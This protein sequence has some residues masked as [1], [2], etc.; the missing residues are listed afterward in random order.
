MNRGSMERRIGR[1]ARPDSGRNPAREQG[2]SLVEALCA[3]VILGFGLVGITEAITLS[4]RSS[5]N[6][7]YH[8]TAVLLAT[9][10]VETLRAEKYFPTG[11][12]DGDFVD[13]FSLYSWSQDI[14]ETETDGLYDVVVQIKLSSTQEVIYE[15][16]SRLFDQPFDSLYDSD[17]YSEYS[18][19]DSRDRRG[20]DATGRRGS[21]RGGSRGGARRGGGRR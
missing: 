16:R 12:D 18:S 17:E 7:E 5:K 11:E 13:A 8:S 20:R 3:L 6:S 2:F 14:Q 15:L 4:L 1:V 19:N 9:G 21:S 10:I